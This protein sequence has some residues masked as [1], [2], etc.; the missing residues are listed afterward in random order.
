ME[1]KEIID[2]LTNGVGETPYF[3]KTEDGD[4][5]IFVADNQLF[6]TIP[7]YD[8]DDEYAEKVAEAICCAG[9]ELQKAEDSREHN[10]PIITEHLAQI[11]RDIDSGLKRAY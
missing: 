1:I 3:R 5:D 11:K 4:V 2:C 9:G 10:K 8:D 7:R 6:C